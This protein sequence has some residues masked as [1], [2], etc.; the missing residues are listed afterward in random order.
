MYLGDE[1]A[2]KRT[3]RLRWISGILILLFLFSFW[4]D[5]IIVLGLLKDFLLGVILGNLRLDELI[6]P[7][8][9]KSIWVLSYN[10]LLGFGLV[11][12][13]WLFMLAGQAVLP[14]QG[15]VDTYRAA[16]HLLL[17][18]LHM[19]GPAVF[20]KDGKNN[21]T[22]EDEQRKGPGVAVV[23]FNSAIVLEARVPPPGIG[24]LIDTVVQTLM[25]M[26]GLNDQMAGTRAAGPGI[27]FM[28]EHEKIRGTV[29]LRTQF[30][31]I[32]GITAYTRDGIEVKS[33]IFSSFTVGQDADIVQ[34]TYDGD[35][36]PENLRVITLEKLP[37]KKLRLTGMSDELDANDRDEIHHYIHVWQ[38]GNAKLSYKQPPEPETGYNPDRVFASVFSEARDSQDKLIPWSDLPVRVAAGFFREMMSQVNYDQLYNV[39]ATENFPIPAYKAKLRNL[40]RN[41]GLLSYRLVFHKSDQPLQKRIVYSESDLIISEVRHLA[42]PKMLRDRGIKVITAGFGDIQAVNE[43][44]YQ[45]R[46]Q[47]WRA[48]WQRETDIIGATRELEAARL[49][50][51]ARAQAQQEL[52]VSLNDILQNQTISR[53]VMAVRILQALE[54]LA[55]ET[56]TKDILPG[57]TLDILKSTRDWLMPGDVPPS[58]PPGLN[59]PNDGGFEP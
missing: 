17:F 19:H 30:R 4:Q 6:P 3:Q 7:T 59:F 24:R 39:G 55:A 52:L 38:R 48:T 53:E 42:F 1:S 40:M 10:L 23:D 28:T 14:V 25:V 50:N 32:P 20:I 11:F 46:L 37:E 18:M 44:L 45:R 47:A 54:N 21:S 2:K 43:Q 16:F 26:L 57:G 41:N 56:K 36:R 29:D 12:F 13:F 22:K 5:I 31:G 15:F 8:S 51:H 35:P 58:L 34:V 33:R 27:V 49:R 9:W